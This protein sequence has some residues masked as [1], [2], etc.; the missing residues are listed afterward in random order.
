LVRRQVPTTSYRTG[1]T[2]TIEN[3]RT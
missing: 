1:K 2:L 3:Y